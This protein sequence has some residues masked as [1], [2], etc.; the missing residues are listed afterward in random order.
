MFMYVGN[1]REFGV[2]LRNAFTGHDF[3]VLVNEAVRLILGQAAPNYS[4]GP[5]NEIERKG[6]VVVQ[7]SDVNLI[8]AA[9]SLYGRFFGK[10]IA[11]HFNS[12]G[13]LTLSTIGLHFFNWF[14]FRL[15]KCC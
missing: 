15:M 11:L 2:P 3:E 4:L 6:S 8:W 12:V 7:A 5:F 9:L 10:P 1:Y 14:H 13:F